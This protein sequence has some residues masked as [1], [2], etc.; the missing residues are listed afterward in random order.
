MSPL[1]PPSIGCHA[2]TAW[3]CQLLPAPNLAPNPPA[4]AARPCPNGSGFL[5]A[6][7]LPTIIKMMVKYF[8][9]CSNYA[10][11]IKHWQ[12]A[13]RPPCR[14]GEEAS[15][16]EHCAVSP[17][18]PKSCRMTAG[19]SCWH[20]SP[21]P[22]SPECYPGGLN[23]PRHHGLELLGKLP[24]RSLSFHFAEP[25]NHVFWDPDLPRWHS[26]CHLG[27]GGGQNSF[28]AHRRF[29]L[30]GLELLE[31]FSAAP[32]PPSILIPHPHLHSHPHPSYPSFI[33]IPIIHLQ[34][35]SSSPSS[36]LHLHPHPHPLSSSPSP[37]HH[38]TRAEG[39]TRAPALPARWRPGQTE[40]QTHHAVPLTHSQDRPHQ[41]GVQG[42]ASLSCWAMGLLVS[43]QALHRAPSL[44]AGTPQHLV[45]W[46][47]DTTI[48]MSQ[49]R[50]CPAWTLKGSSGVRELQPKGKEE[51][52]ENEQKKWYFTKLLLPF[53]FPAQKQ[54][55][56]RLTLLKSPP[57]APLG[58]P[59]VPAAPRARGCAGG[60]CPSLLPAAAAG[61]CRAV[62]RMK[63]FSR[64]E[65][66]WQRGAGGAWMLSRHL[67][68]QQRKAAAVP[69]HPP[70]SPPL[71]SPPQR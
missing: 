41:L 39:R 21:P 15:W 13:A 36:I 57:R 16:G 4:K 46:P 60:S 70:R 50:G 66:G 19:D 63:P 68:L 6:S 62:M 7:A 24:S 56:S 26:T 59:A 67:P 40:G 2:G 71:P 65:R 69:G 34:P 44:Q 25:F 48:P 5:P 49:P 58:S 37:S 11:I 30:P 47:Q 14:E 10:Q 20:L 64:W 27:A 42:P 29:L 9:I 54:T 22:K 53:Y 52:E 33:R 45:G 3:L 8:I 1:Q 51:K 17:Q 18:T 38:L 61:P 31:M 32:F 23:P 43:S 12:P 55:S 35:P 28:S